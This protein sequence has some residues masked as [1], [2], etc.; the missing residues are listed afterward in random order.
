MYDNI[1]IL[2]GYIPKKWMYTGDENNVIYVGDTI[3]NNTK[4]IVFSIEKNSFSIEK[5]SIQE[6][7]SD[8]DFK[9]CGSFLYKTISQEA[10]LF[11]TDNLKNLEPSLICNALH[12]FHGETN[13]L[14]EQ[15]SKIS[16]D[17]SFKNNGELNGKY[18][19]SILEIYEDN[20]CTESRDLV[21]LVN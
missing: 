14:S 15:L 1:K 5:T 6:S 18:Y 16:S 20:G 21:F 12:Y 3:Y 2:V 9:N 4:E 7:F 19:I 17:G 11:L 10:A 8:D 13:I